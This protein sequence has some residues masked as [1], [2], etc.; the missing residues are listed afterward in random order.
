MLNGTST[1]GLTAQAEAD[2]K[3]AGYPVVATGNAVSTRYAATVVYYHPGNLDKA[4]LL[5]QVYGGATVAPL[6]PQIQAGGD[7]VVVLGQDYAQGKVTAV[8]S[9]APT[10]PVGPAIAG[11]AAVMPTSSMQVS[12]C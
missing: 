8:P 9:A 7:A 1:S 10:P 12:A 6:P 4:S 5:A 11:P 2:L 3:A